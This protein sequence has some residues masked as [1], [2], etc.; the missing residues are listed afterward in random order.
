MNAE[1]VLESLAI[2]MIGI[3]PEDETVVVS[4]NRGQP[5]AIEGKSKAGQAFKNIA[6]R[7]NGEEV[8]FLNLDE[9][10]DFFSRFSKMISKGGG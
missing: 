7:L 10:D 9:K 4:T 5:V 1:D 2:P 6:H 3:I 8:P